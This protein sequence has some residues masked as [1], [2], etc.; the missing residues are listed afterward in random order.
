LRY[1]KSGRVIVTAGPGLRRNDFD[2]INLVLD[3]AEEPSVQKVTSFYNMSYLPVRGAW[4]YRDSFQILPVPPGAPQPPYLMAEW[5]FIVET[6]Y[7]SSSV[8]GISTMRML[9]AIDDLRLTIPIV[10]SG[11]QYNPNLRRSSS[12]W[13]VAHDGNETI[14]PLMGQPHYFA[15]NYV[16]PKD[17]LTKLEQSSLAELTSDPTY[18]T[19]T[20]MTFDD[21]LMIPDAAQ[22]LFDRFFA[23]STS[24]L[25]RF[26]IAAYW[27]NM[28]RFYW[29]YS[30]STS[31][32]AAVIAIESLLPTE[33]PH[34][35][36]ECGQPHHPS[37]TKAF[38]SFLAQHVP[39]R[40]GRD[41]FYNVRSKISH[42][43]HVLAWDTAAAFGGADPAGVEENL[44]HG[45]LLY[46]CRIALLN[47]LGGQDL[48]P[49]SA[50]LSFPMAPSG[51]KVIRR[52]AKS[53]RVE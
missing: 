15:D 14:G 29:H 38:R 33:A 9:R 35:C 26:R 51:H 50:P 39:D 40:E 30:T 13:F 25:R 21:E 31:Y 22:A 53:V 16:A 1:T 28:A 18:F 27:Y 34:S 42:G 24:L 8:P 32:L 36:P 20:G 41:E 46:T 52:S 48:D 44:S 45:R 43:S 49:G 3:R 4:R 2:Q 5:P 7:Q 10:F 11:P 19:P 47:W 17:T 23:L 37:I 12:R 6:Y